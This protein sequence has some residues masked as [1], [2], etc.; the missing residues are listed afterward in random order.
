MDK[1]INDIITE[2]DKLIYFNKS[3]FLSEQ[4]VDNIN[5]YNQDGTV[6]FNYDPKAAKQKEVLNK[7][8][9]ISGKEKKDD[10]IKYFDFGGLSKIPYVVGTKFYRLTDIDT[11]RIL[12]LTKKDKYGYYDEIDV[13]N[14]GE[15]VRRYYPTNDW[16]V[17]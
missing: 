13:E 15:P 7:F 14:Y 5:Q 16:S 3:I 6:N 2:I 17:I 1:K 10:K 12:G 11:G 9:P 4:S 8:T